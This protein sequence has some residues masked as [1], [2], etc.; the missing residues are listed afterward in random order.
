MMPADK[1][2]CD[3]F[4]YKNVSPVKRIHESLKPI[5]LIQQLVKFCTFENDIVLDLFAGS[6]S[7]AK[8]CLLENRNSISFEI[9][10]KQ[11]IKGV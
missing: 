8:A 3:I 2:I 1:S 6:G 4:H 10:T 11:F 9:D 7:V 5:E